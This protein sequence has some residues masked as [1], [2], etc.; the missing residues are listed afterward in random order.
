MLWPE[1][2]RAIEEYKRVR[3]QC[4]GTLVIS[5]RGIGFSYDG[6]RDAFDRLKR[7]A[8]LSEVTFDQV[9]DGALTAASQVGVDSRDQDIL[10]GHRCGMKD[11]YI[12]R[13]PQRTQAAVDA[14]REHY[15]IADLVK[16]Q[17][18]GRRAAARGRAPRGR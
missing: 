13:N 8:G 15:R 12:L 7:V 3:P 16:P 5:A 11:N 6:F 4:G 9:R 10:A 2:V 18:P 17:K 14:I 1:T